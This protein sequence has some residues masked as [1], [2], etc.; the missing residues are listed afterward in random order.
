MLDPRRGTYFGLGPTGSRIW[1][2]LEGPTAVAD[3]CAALAAEYDVAL[4]V[5]LRDTVAFLEQLVAADLVRAV[6]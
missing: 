2:L 1:E 3:V 4:E 5:C 6:P